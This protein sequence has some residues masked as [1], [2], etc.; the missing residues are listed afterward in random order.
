MCVKPKA[1]VIRAQIDPQSYLAAAVLAAAAEAAQITGRP[2]ENAKKER[3]EGEGGKT[4]YV[5]TSYTHA[6]ASDFSTRVFK[7]TRVLLRIISVYD[8][9]LF[10]C[11]VTH[12]RV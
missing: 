3:G 5:R 6:V 7:A 1:C 9:D 8:C 12:P 10:L 4:A 2:K 11:C